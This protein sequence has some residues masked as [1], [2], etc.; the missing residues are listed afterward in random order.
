[1]VAEREAVEQMLSL[2]FHPN[3]PDLRLFY[4]TLRIILWRISTAALVQSCFSLHATSRIIVG[5]GI[6][7]SFGRELLPLRYI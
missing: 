4:D 2:R 5:E 6:Y 1:V 3:S 7:C